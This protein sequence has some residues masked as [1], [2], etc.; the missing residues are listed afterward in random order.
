MK[1]RSQEHDSPETR[2]TEAEQKP[3]R[4]QCRTDPNAPHHPAKLRPAEPDGRMHP[5]PREA[6][7]MVQDNRGARRWADGRQASLDSQQQAYAPERTAGG[8]G[9]QSAPVVQG[10]PPKTN[11]TPQPP[12]PGFRWALPCPQAHL[13]SGSLRNGTGSCS[14]AT[15]TPA[16]L[17]CCANRN[18]KKLRACCAM[19]RSALTNRNLYD[20]PRPAP[21]RANGEET[22][23]R[24]LSAAQRKRPVRH[25]NTPVVK[26]GKLRV[27]VREVG[28]M[29]TCFCV[30]YIFNQV[31][32]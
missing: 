25:R 29:D 3:P 22:R 27:S 30:I 15:W 6:G 24:C 26:M 13:S 11:H 28:Q 14:R 12:A 16:R 32:A 7:E 1:T 21:T 23:G 10:P 19:I 8:T 5:K 4:E 31:I 18:D 17:R 9:L 20:R 2:R